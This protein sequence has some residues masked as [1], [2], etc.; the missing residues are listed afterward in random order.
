MGAE[1]RCVKGGGDRE[2][3][4]QPSQGCWFPADRQSSILN[5]YRRCCRWRSRRQRSF[6]QAVGKAP[7]IFHQNHVYARKQTKK[8]VCLLNLPCSLSVTH[9]HVCSRLLIFSRRSRSNLNTPLPFRPELVFVFHF[10]F[11]G[12]CSCQRVRICVHLDFMDRF[13]PTD[14]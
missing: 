1:G 2:P 12:S 11:C 10:V 13:D 6:Y 4:A 7:L 14:G 5:A 8:E 9:T 3:A